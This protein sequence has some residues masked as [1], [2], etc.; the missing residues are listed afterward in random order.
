MSRNVR[1][2]FPQTPVKAAKRRGSDSSNS[3]VD[4][5]SDGGYSALDE[6]SDDS[7]DDD[8]EGVNAA[9]EEHMIADEL[10]TRRRDAGPPRPES[11]DEEDDADGEDDGGGDDDDDDDD[12]D[13][14]D[15]NRNGEVDDDAESGSWAGIVSEVESPSGPEY[16]VKS[17]DQAGVKRQVRFAVPDSDSDS[18]STTTET[19]ND[20]H[21]MFPDIFVAQASLD[22]GFRREIEQ[23]ADDASSVASYWDFHDT[24][25]P[26]GATGQRGLVELLEEDD[27]EA[28][29]PVPS[30]E[31]AE[32][33]D[34]YDC[35]SR[36][37][38][39]SAKRC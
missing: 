15:M 12:D 24:T 25:S 35:E 26:D 13:N 37:T 17:R 8:E 19:S 10:D 18:D 11:D 30:P 23:D 5:S 2:K 39:A 6:D 3:S 9:E 20:I 27:A 21:D 4:L 22:P 16:A 31:D 36:D 1:Q 34:G 28:S 7:E 38:S 32:D 14:L 33:L 29:T